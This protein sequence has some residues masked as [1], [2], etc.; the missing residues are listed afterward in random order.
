MWVRFGALALVVVLC[1]ALAAPFLIPVND[2]RPLL[3]DA[4]DN[5][6]G[7]QVEIDG[8]KLS[9]LPNVHISIEGFRLRNPSGFPAGDALTA[10]TIDLGL[11]TRALLSRQLDVTYVAPS[12]VVLNVIRDEAGRTNLTFAPRDA[13]SSHGS[14]VTLESIGKIDV[15]GATFTFATLPQGQQPSFSLSGLHANVGSIDP[16]QKNF[17]EKIDVGVDLSGAR[18]TTS[19]LTEPVDF[20]TGAF[21]FKDGGGRG[22]FALS[23]ANV[24][25]SG[26][27]AFA[28]LDPLVISFA[29]QSPE[30]N[31][32]TLPSLVRGGTETPVSASRRLLA[33]GT[34][35]IDKITFATFAATNFTG[36]LGVYTNGLDVQN[37]ALSAYG[38][39][40]H[41]SA[42]VD[43]GKAGVPLT[44]NVQV[45][46]V[47]IQDVMSAVGR[48][49]VSGTLDAN[50]Q[51]AL[52][53][54]RNPEQSLISSGTFSVTNGTLPSSQLPTFRYF[55]GDLRIAQERGHSN[56]L[57]LAA[58]GLQATLSGSFGFDQTI[59]YAGTA[60]VNAPAQLKSAAQIRVIFAQMMRRELGTTRATVPFA[61][62]G[63]VA[64]PQFKMTGTPQLVNSSVQLP[65]TTVPSS[66][67]NLLQEVP[68]LGI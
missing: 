51:I 56:D 40:A 19:L 32:D 36:A 67:Q 39:T 30:I 31:L 10:K 53:L 66:L 1:G 28:R 18:L 23:I 52:E 16:Q 27:V 58:K 41:G 29:V 2:Y 68:G 26:A 34:A 15:T 62:Y 50:T 63:S 9:L 33:R 21:D 11:N 38:G 17:I 25:L 20:R 54:Q 49:G 48:R 5:A 43:T 6:T 46:G 42:S 55:G 3:V 8:L 44:G 24:D 59:S 22:T 7:R 14:A 57:R 4:I 12:G 13:S 61:I 45:R 65:N 64:N 60:I 35:R 37:C 47:S